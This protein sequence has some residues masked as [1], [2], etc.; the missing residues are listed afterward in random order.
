VTEVVKLVDFEVIPKCIVVGISSPDRY[1]DLTPNTMT[2]A[3]T[4]GNKRF[5]EYLTKEVPAHMARKYTTPVFPILVGHS[6]GASFAQNAMTVSPAAF[7]G[8]IC[9]SQNFFG[10]EL[11][12]YVNYTKE[13]FSNNQYFFIASGTR[14]ATSRRNSGRLMD[15]LFQLNNNA[16]LKV[17]HE[18]YAADHSGIVAFGLPNAIGFVFSDYVQPNGW[19]GAITDSLKRIKMDPMVLIESTMARINAIY[20][21]D[22]QP[23]DVLS[24][25]RSLITNKDQ[26]KDY[27]DHLPQSRKAGVEFHSSVAQLYESIHE[28][29]TALVYW[30]KQ[31][32]DTHSYKQSFFY[33]RRPIELLAYKMNQPAKAIAFA[34]EWEKK[35]P[36]K[37][38]LSFKY[39][40]AKVAAE[41][42][43]NKKKGKEY[44]GYFINNYDPK[45]TGYSLE[46]AKK[47]QA[48]LEKK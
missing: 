38:Q 13:N 7:R 42:N 33:F 4:E 34:E 30:T 41:K 17:R 20:G 9:L 26:A 36:E 37:V 12:R 1:I 6:D 11:N 31:L 45:K 27:L 21:I 32:T 25:A 39:F 29:D 28:Y 44:I 15:S 46:E 35:A 23:T 43:V 10:D 14:D 2:G 22:A 24:Q 48:D 3:L 5:I 40:M 18:V 19:D 47:V 16:H 8:V